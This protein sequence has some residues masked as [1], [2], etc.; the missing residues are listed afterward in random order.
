MV[1]NDKIMI[2]LLTAFVL[3]FTS[4]NECTPRFGVEYNEQRCKNE[5][6][7]LPEGWSI[8]SCG[9][10]DAK[11]TNRECGENCHLSKDVTYDENGLK[12]ELDV[13]V[14]NKFYPSRDGD[15]MNR[16][17]VLIRYRK[18]I[19]PNNPFKDKHWD[20]DIRDSLHIWVDFHKEVTEEE[21]K[22]KLLEWGINL[23]EL[24]CT[25]K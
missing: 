8:S 11:W 7:D 10:F 1:R 9:E 4:C 18:E 13:F 2:F 24:K 12:E 19:D 20:Y 15:G 17:E 21:V 25:S 16:E 14:G 23:D 6:V 22:Q 3:V 5:Q